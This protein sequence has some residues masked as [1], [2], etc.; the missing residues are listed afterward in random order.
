[1]AGIKGIILSFVAIGIFAFAI[2]SFGVKFGGENQVNASLSNIEGLEAFNNTLSSNINAYS[3]QVNSSEVSFSKSEPTVGGESLQIESTASIWKN[4]IAIPKA[5]YS[6]TLGFILDNIFG[7]SG[8]EFSPIFTL[9]T[10]IIVGIIILY[11]WKWIRGGDP[12]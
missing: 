10:A 6:S 1:M 3:S 12:D 9:I 11:A 2:I 4:L 8:G 5:M 7:G